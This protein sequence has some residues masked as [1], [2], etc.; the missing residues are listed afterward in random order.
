M[1]SIEILTYDRSRNFPSGDEEA[2]GLDVALIFENRRHDSL[3][4]V[5]GYFHSHPSV[6]R[7]IRRVE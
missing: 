5:H 2:Q 1:A 4:N 6:A 7:R 3:P